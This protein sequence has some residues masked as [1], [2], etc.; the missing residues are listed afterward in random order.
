MQLKHIIFFVF[1]TQL[2]FILIWVNVPFK[3][4]THGIRADQNMMS[5]P[6]FDL[7]RQSVQKASRSVNHILNVSESNMIKSS[8]LSLDSQ[9]RHLRIACMGQKHI[10]S[11]ASFYMRCKQ[12]RFY[13]KHY[14]KD[15]IIDSLAYK[16]A[17]KVIEPYDAA[18]FIKTTPDSKLWP[19]ILK[20]F[21]KIYVDVI[22]GDS[23]VT[24]NLIDF[25]Y[26]K[27]L[28]PRPVLIVQNVYQQ[29]LYNDTY[30]TAIIEHMPASLNQTELVDVSSFRH[31]L[32]A[33]SLM[34]SGKYASLTKDLCID[35]KTQSVHL[36]CLSTLKE[37]IA[38]EKEL[39]VN[40]EV[41]KSKIWGVP[42]LYTQL[43]R[44]YDVI[45]VFTKKGEK[46]KI[47][48]VQRMTNAIYSGVITVIQRTGLH[49]LYVGK[50]YPCSFTNQ[51]ELKNVLQTLDKNVS[52]RMECQRQAKLINNLF[53]P[54]NIIKK[55]YGM[56]TSNSQ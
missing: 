54:E 8:T 50:N 19:N 29:N 35:I 20:N 49:V 42:W 26:L 15:V 2:L 39:K 47:N 3:L 14:L 38:I 33:I 6:W 22:D 18:I 43:M 23:D 55:Y 13:A 32:Q 28:N 17:A 24:G 45:V 40:Y 46:T 11:W 36:K 12:L 56:L 51:N 1:L 31:P 16:Q 48:S 53:L 7:G 52:M 41:Y 5:S 10:F 34:S 21:R 4:V 37:K 44:K 25:N 27:T 30:K 9:H